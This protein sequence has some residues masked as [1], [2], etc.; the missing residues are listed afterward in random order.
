VK[1]LNK[2]HI[3]VDRLRAIKSKKVDQVEKIGAARPGATDTIFVVTERLPLKVMRVPG[4]GGGGGG[5]WGVCVP[6]RR[7][8]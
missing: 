8:W 3:V 6:A 5:G 7:A 1:L 4:R 2:D